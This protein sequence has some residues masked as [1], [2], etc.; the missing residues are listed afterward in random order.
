MRPRFLPAERQ[1]GY[2]DFEMFP[3]S[4]ATMC[5]SP[6]FYRWN[7]TNVGLWFR[8]MCAISLIRSCFNLGVFCYIYSWVHTLNQSGVSVV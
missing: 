1:H 2:C 8:F 4:L 3:C 7:K 6:H 5:P